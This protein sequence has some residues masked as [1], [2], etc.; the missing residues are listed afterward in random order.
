MPPGRGRAER[1]GYLAD[2]IAGTSG[3]ARVETAAKA[4]TTAG[5][6]CPAASIP[7][8]TARWAAACRRAS[9]IWTRTSIAG[10]RLRRFAFHALSPVV[11]A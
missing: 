6:G 7:R 8:P 4:E 2:E 11:K 1:A 5:G 10:S 9:A 3:A